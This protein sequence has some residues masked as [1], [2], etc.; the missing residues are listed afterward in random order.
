M[1][2][3]VQFIENKKFQV[4]TVP[5]SWIKNGILL[6][7]KLSNEKI[8][9]LRESGAEFHGSVKRIPVIIWKKI[10][11]FEAAERAAD[12][13]AKTE[14]SDVEGKKK[15]LKQSVKSKPVDSKDYNAMFAGKTKLFKISIKSL[16][17]PIISHCRSAEQHPKT[18]SWS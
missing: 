1:F 7:P 12:D 17:H 4:L 15:I 18:Y 16:L 8:E 11:S 13:L 9:K 14:V 2:A 5:M 10:R 3:V 6:W